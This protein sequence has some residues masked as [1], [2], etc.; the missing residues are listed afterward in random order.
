MQ[1][2]NSESCGRRRAPH[3][4]AGGACEQSVVASAAPR[5]LPDSSELDDAEV[6]ASAMD[7]LEVLAPQL[8]TAP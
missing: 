5:R 3:S 8:R 7:V 2:E 1:S 4:I 6:E